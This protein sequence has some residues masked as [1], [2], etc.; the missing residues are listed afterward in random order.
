MC[1]SACWVWS[2]GF[3]RVSAIFA[4]S[5]RVFV[6]IVVLVS[7]GCWVVSA[8]RSLY[9]A[10]SLFMGFCGVFGFVFVWKY[11]E[12]IRPVVDIVVRM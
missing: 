6:C 8:I 2:M 7:G 5:W 11:V 3:A 12:K 9:G 10:V 1:S 4:R